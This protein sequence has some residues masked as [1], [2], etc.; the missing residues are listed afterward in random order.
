MKWQAILRT[1][2]VTVPHFESHIKSVIDYVSYGYILDG[3]PD[4]AIEGGHN[5]EQEQKGECADSEVLKNST[6]ECNVLQVLSEDDDDDK[7]EVVTSASKYYYGKKSF[8]HKDGH[9]W[10]CFCVLWTLQQ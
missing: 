9:S 1:I 5:A 4:Y 7:G 6:I 3:D 10:L 8:A 2:S